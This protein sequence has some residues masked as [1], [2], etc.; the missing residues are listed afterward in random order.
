MN[1]WLF[2]C[3]LSANSC[4]LNS[5]CRSTVGDSFVLFARFHSLVTMEKKVFKCLPKSVVPIH[6]DITIK[7]D[8]VKLL[9]EG[10]ENVDL[11]VKS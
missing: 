5:L 7:P 6:Y 8:L 9:F 11:K 4:G 3:W 2:R 1:D 10:T